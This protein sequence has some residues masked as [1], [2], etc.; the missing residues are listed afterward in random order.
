[1]LIGDRS[2][3]LPRRIASTSTGGGGHV[4]LASGDPLYIATPPGRVSIRTN[5]A[6]R[7]QPVCDARHLLDRETHVDEQESLVLVGT[8]SSAA[9]DRPSRHPR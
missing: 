2:Q 7:C 4:I 6:R 5:A 8:I 3:D 9:G 1:M